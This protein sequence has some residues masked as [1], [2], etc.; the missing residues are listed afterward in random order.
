MKVFITV[1]FIVF[2]ITLQ[3]KIISPPEVRTIDYD[4]KLISFPHHVEGKK[5]RG[6]WVKVVDKFSKKKLCLRK[7]W[8]TPHRKDIQ[9]DSQYNFVDRVKQKGE[10]ITIFDKNN[11]VHKLFASD[12][13]K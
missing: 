7:I 5:Q 8:N 10:I 3:A 6:G 13:C 11:N 4:G 2:F 9:M 12:I 1:S